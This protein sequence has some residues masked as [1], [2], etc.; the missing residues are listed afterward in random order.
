MNTTTDNTRRLMLLLGALIAA[1]AIVVIAIAVSSS[2]GGSKK[3]PVKTPTAVTGR[4]GGGAFAGIP[5]SGATLGNP[6]APVTVLEFA[7][8]QCP[9]CR[10]FTLNT[11][12]Q[13]V[14]QYV[15][16]GRVKMQFHNF[17]FLGHDSIPAA[18]AAAVAEQHN[19]L[20]DFVDAWYHNQGEENS[21]YAT[22]PF[23]EKIATMA[24]LNG[25]AIIAA[26]SSPST[27]AVLRS[28]ASLSQRFKV[29]STPTLIVVDSSGRAQSV[30]DYTQLPAT[31]ASVLGG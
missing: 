3:S 15:R 29:N 8:L 5:Q 22:T 16:P 10:D 17:P 6:N 21:G 28:D 1:A 9:F 18:R 4:G 13:V 20:W 24:G 30:S 2:G 25:P 26:E 27:A 14:S 7:D 12:P 31:I 19:R 23:V 11:F